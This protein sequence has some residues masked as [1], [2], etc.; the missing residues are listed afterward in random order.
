ML[1]VG[2]LL[3][4]APV[5]NPGVSW[6]HA[7]ALDE[8]FDYYEQLMEMPLEGSTIIRDTLYGEIKIHGDIIDMRLSRT[9][10]V[11]AE[12]V[13]FVDGA[14]EDLCRVLCHTL[15]AE[16][17]YEWRDLWVKKSIL[18]FVL[19]NYPQYLQKT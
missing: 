13:T 10:L 17:L 6:F 15:T 1:R 18:Q 7:Q 2:D 3:T 12:T 11:V 5:I 16:E 19:D 9:C 4:G 8:G 14:R